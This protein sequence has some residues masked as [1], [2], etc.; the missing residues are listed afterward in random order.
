[1]TNTFF[2]FKQYFSSI[3]CA[4]VFS[5]MLSACSSN[6]FSVGGTITNM[7]KQKLYLE[8]MGTD[9]IIKIDSTTTEEDGTFTLKGTAA[10]PSLFRLRFEKGKYLLVTTQN[11]KVKIKSDWDN[12]E[13]YTVMNSAGSLTLKTFLTALRQHLLDL[14]TYDKITNSLNERTQAN[15]DSVMLALST[16]INAAN[17]NFVDYVQKFADTTTYLPNAMFAVNILNSD[18]QGTYLKKFF[19]KLEARYPGSALAKDFTKMYS[20]R[21]ANVPEPPKPSY[22]PKGDGTYNVR[23]ADAVPATEIDLATSEGNVIKLSKYKGKYLLIDFW[24]SWCAPCRK[25]NPNVLSAYNIYKDRNFTIL[26][27][28]LDTDAA[29]WVKTI[30]D[31]GLEWDHVI[32]TRKWGAPVLRK[33]NITSI[34]ANVLVDPDGYIIAR[35]LQGDELLQKLESI[36][37]KK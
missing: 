30:K 29:Q 24:A 35:N 8:S 17:K 22:T 25:E 4:I 33:Y 21:L 2:S 27:V 23:A 12:M 16:E 15:K 14:K 11:D 36:F 5:I 26:G 32:D 28:S 7:P 1:M 31:D 9:T 13:D 19:D 18:V 20:S 10:E 34:P 3:V 6:E 37:A